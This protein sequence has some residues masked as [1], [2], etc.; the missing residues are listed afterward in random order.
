M[1]NSHSGI[2]EEEKEVEPIKKN[3][4]N[5]YL[6]EKLSNLKRDNKLGHSGINFLKRIFKRYTLSFETERGKT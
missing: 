4:G 3:L 1:S 6:E 5:F 2:L